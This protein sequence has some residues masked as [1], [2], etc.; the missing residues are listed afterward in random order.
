MEN[1]NKTIQNNETVNVHPGS[2]TNSMTDTINIRELVFKYLNKWYWFLISVIVCFVIAYGYLKITNVQYQVQTSILLRKDPGQSGLLDMSMLDGLGLPNASSKEVED[3]I[4]V[5]SSKTLIKNVITSLDAETEYFVQTGFKYTELYPITPLKLVVPNQFNDTATSPIEFKIIKNKNVYNIKYKCNKEKGSYNIKNLSSPIKTPFGLFQFVKMSEIKEGTT[6]KI[7]TYPYR[8]LTEI[9][10]ANIKIAAA[11][12]KSNAITVSTVSS[13][14]YKSEMILDKVIELYNLDAVLDKNKIATN[15]ANFIQDRLKLISSELMEVEVDVENYKKKN[16]L[17][18]LSSEAELFLKSA[19]EYDKKLA[20]LETQLNLV[21]YIE[22]H[23]KESKNQYGLIPANLGIED[24]SLIELVQEYNKA[25][26]E[27]LKLRRTSNDLN[28]VMTQMEQQLKELRVSIIASIS[29]IKAGLNIAKK[30][31]LDKDSQFALKI[32]DVPTQERQYL[33]I[34]RQQEIK[35]KLYLYLLQKREENALSLA[36]TIPSAKT[37][38][39][40]YTTITPVSPKRMM[41]FLIAII[42]GLTLPTGIIYILELFNNK[43]T[44]KKELQKLVKVPFL[45][46]I[47][48]NKNADRIVVKEGITTPIVE[49][50]RLIRTNLNFMLGGN[51]SPVILV[52][53]TISGEGKSFTAI[54]M[55]LSF[56]L[57]QKKVILVGLDVRNPMLGEYMHISKAEGI[58]MYLADPTLKSE[59]IIIPSG[60][61]PF[62]DVIPAGPVPPNPSELLLSNRLDELIQV[63]KE[64][65]DY[66]ILDS[67]PVG[68]VS[69]TYLLNRLVDNCIYVTRQNYTPREATALISEIYKHKRINKIALVLNGTDESLGYGYGYG[70]GYSSDRTR[71]NSKNARS[72]PSRIYRKLRNK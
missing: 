29:S 67:A 10:S 55:A 33:E 16:N 37:L 31:V 51:K 9:Y 2:N 59:N 23:I 13:S 17:T 12:K 18:D 65:Y 70:Y 21:G 54:N 42:L 53:S 19:S 8:L 27:R 57:L 4:Q 15:T 50:F 72:A 44:D 48:V 63:L 1:T 62:L 6:L 14:P 3:E 46:S 32:K 20:E 30:D 26:L 45:G 25:L 71:N 5:L 38:D 47:A 58:S 28:P 56:A 7:R 49:M 69:D 11:T 22:T 40:A 43:I 60:F 41:I 64:Q 52:T 66:I 35:Q 39:K 34:K 24:K 36:S 68:V 61:H